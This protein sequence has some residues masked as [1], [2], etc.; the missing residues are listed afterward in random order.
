MDIHDQ[1]QD[2][3]GM[4]FNFQPKVVADVE[5]LQAKVAGLNTF[6]ITVHEDIIAFIILVNIE[7]VSKHE[8]GSEFR[9]AMHTI[10]HQYTYNSVHD[11]ALSRRFSRS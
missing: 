4:T 3:L 9:T 1:L 7:D 5:Q 2:I 8:W 6:G 11:S 10:R